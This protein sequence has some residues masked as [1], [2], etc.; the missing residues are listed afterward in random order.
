MKK[1]LILFFLAP[2]ISFG[3][4]VDGDCDN[5]VGTYV[6]DDGSVTN[7]SWTNGQADGVVQE[8]LY[9]DEGRLI[10]TYDGIMEMG[11]MQGWGTATLYDEDGTLLGTYVGEFVNNEYNGWGIW[12]WADK[13]IEKGIWKNGELVR[14]I[15]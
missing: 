2:I 4:C 11:V 13:A 10:G 9:D 1:I 8:I 5:G 7:G 14:E 12:I 15:R 3:Q 6:F